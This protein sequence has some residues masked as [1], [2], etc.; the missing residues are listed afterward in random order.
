MLNKING[1]HTFKIA[2]YMFTWYCGAAIEVP[3]NNS[4]RIGRQML[5]QNPSFL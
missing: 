3:H 4:P 5:D 1:K 2:L